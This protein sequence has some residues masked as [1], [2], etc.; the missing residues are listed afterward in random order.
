M[1]VAVRRHRSRRIGARVDEYRQ[2]INVQCTMNVTGNEKREDAE[3]TRR[4]NAADRRAS[5]TFSFGSRRFTSRGVRRLFL[6]QKCL[7][8][9]AFEPDGLRPHALLPRPLP[10]AHGC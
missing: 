9:P 1:D 7:I 5:A 4:A 8:S 6:P 2:R 10:P 3:N